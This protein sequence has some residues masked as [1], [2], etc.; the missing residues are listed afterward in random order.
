MSGRIGTSAQKYRGLHRMKL[1]GKTFRGY[2]LEYNLL[3]FFFFPIYCFFH[4]C[5][6]GAWSALRCCSVQLG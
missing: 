4:H 3:C 6:E 1:N 2:S 5:M